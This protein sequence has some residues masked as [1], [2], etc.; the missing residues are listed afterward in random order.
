MFT[1]H[2]SD[3][4]EALSEPQTLVKQ[5]LDATI[6]TLKRVQEPRFFE[7]ERG[8]QGYFST[9]LHNVLTKR[10]I[11]PDK[12]IVEEEY[13][14]TKG[15]HDTSLR[16][17]LIIHRPADS[18]NPRRNN[19]CVY[20]LKRHASGKAAQKDFEKLQKMFEKLDYEIGVFINIDSKKHHLDLWSGGRNEQVHAFAVWRSKK[21]VMV[22]HAAWKN[23]RI[24][25]VT[26]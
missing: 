5:V 19:L 1:N 18:A 21:S 8:F 12:Y 25:E 20:L 22:L 10:K 2:E 6:Q 14:K 11:L 17:D 13:Q 23:G 24:F 15:R 26:D 9:I 7:T 4:W 16:P 3:W